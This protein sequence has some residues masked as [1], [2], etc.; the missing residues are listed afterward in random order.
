MLQ[1]R[2]LDKKQLVQIK[3]LWEKLNIVHLQDSVF[4]KEH[5][6]SFSFE[7]R[8]KKWMDAP[9][10]KIRILVGYNSEN[11]IIGYCVSTISSENRGE[12]DSLNVEATFRKQG[13]GRLLL[14]Q[15]LEWLKSQECSPI[16]LSVSY[17]HESV[18]SFYQ[19]MGLYPRL[20]VLEL[21]E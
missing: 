20:M 19:K 4:F 14:E 17:G 12:V 6:A 21:K 2:A 1:I 10:E 5:Y 15:S 8:A 7:K 3:P 11:E 16:R 18:L 9:D 13:V